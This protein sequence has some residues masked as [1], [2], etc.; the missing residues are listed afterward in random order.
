MRIT[1]IVWLKQFSE[2]IATKHRVSG[3][4]VE[5]VF[6]NRARFELE[7]RGDIAGEDL[8]RATGQ[9]DAGRYLVVFFIL[10]RLGRALVISARDA[11]RQERKRYAKKKV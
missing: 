2:K 8:Y 5:Q 4:E 1:Q 3:E 6:L 11:T 9:T 7:E 10:K